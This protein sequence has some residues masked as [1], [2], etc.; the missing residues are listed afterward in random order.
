M[1]K[2]SHGQNDEPYLEH[3][4][5]NLR[6]N[7]AKKFIA[8]NS[9]IADL[10]CGYN[11]NFLKDISN[12]ISRGYGFDISVKKRDLPKNVILKAVDINKNFAIKKGSFD[13]TVALAILEHVENPKKFLLQINQMLKKGGFLILTTPHKRA[14]KILETLSLIGL[15]SK[16]EIDDH[17][18][19]FNE[20]IIKKTLTDTGYKIVKLETF[21]FGFNLLCVAKKR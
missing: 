4:L 13:T 15:I 14:K 8:N 20:N 6:F 5:S 10:G 21:E 9:L 11:G 18:N 3:I 17:K 7:I 12:K 19:Y 16:H 1:R 2:T